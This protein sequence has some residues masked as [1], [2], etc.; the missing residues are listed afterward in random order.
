MKYDVS[1]Q[2]CHKAWSERFNFLCIDISRNK[3]DGKY[4]ILNESKTTYYECIPEGEPFSI[5]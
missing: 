2:M 5:T 1:K 4:R 3:N